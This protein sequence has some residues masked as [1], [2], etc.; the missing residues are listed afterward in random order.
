LWREDFLCEHLFEHKKIPKSEG[1]RSK[2]WKYIRYFEQDPIYEELYDLKND[3][4]ER[5]NFSEDPNYL[6]KLNS[7]RERCDKLL[8]DIRKGIK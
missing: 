7:M 2:N 4:H 5:D 3:P 1:V 8:I 6:E